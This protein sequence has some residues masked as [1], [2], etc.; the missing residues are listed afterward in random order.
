MK[1]VLGSEQALSRSITSQVGRIEL[2]QIASSLD[3]VSA[4][5]EKLSSSCPWGRKELE[6]LEFFKEYVTKGNRQFLS[7]FNGYRRLKPVVYTLYDNPTSPKL[8]QSSCL[9]GFVFSGMKLAWSDHSAKGGGQVRFSPEG[10]GDAGGAGAK[11][12][13]LILR[14]VG[15]RIVEDRRITREE[16]ALYERLLSLVLDEKRKRGEAYEAFEDAATAF[17][18]YRVLQK[19]VSASSLSKEQYNVGQKVLEKVESYIQRGKDSLLDGLEKAI[20]SS[21]EASGTQDLLQAVQKMKRGKREFFD[22]LLFS[23]KKFYRE[24]PVD[25]NR[26]RK[27]LSATKPQ[28][29]RGT[30]AQALED[31]LSSVSSSLTRGGTLKMSDLS[32]IYANAESFSLARR[33]FSYVRDLQAVL[34]ELERTKQ[35]ISK[36]ESKVAE[37][38]SGPATRASRPP[39]PTTRNSDNPR[40]GKVSRG[41]KTFAEL[42]GMRRKRYEL[43]FKRVMEELLVLKELL[44][45]LTKSPDRKGGPLAQANRAFGS[46]FG[47]LSELVD[48]IAEALGLRKL[49]SLEGLLGVASEVALQVL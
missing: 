28:G 24:N 40:G 41:S 48:G 29:L 31:L 23:A 6:D 10:G 26:V 4:E 14:A 20:S 2:E 11:E 37:L 49:W 42:L 39:A 46:A 15:N 32:K 27:V 13:S 44:S 35:L 38:S 19:T 36:A 33:I 17:L 34:K 16:E 47:P 3:R 45:F 1:K 7:A 22:F 30:Q 21:Q 12:E 5:Y 18:L 8:P 9:K 43:L 25:P